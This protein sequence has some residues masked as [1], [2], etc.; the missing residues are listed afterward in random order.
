MAI[1]AGGTQR[2][3]GAL[4]ELTI[5]ILLMLLPVFAVIEYGWLFTREQQVT[6]AARVGARRAVLPDSTNTQVHAVVDQ[7]MAASGLD[8]SGY[9]TT[10]ESGEI[11]D[12]TLVDTAQPITVSVS[13]PY[14]NIDLLDMAMLPVPTNL[15]A[16]VT[17]AKEGPNPPSE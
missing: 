16:S 10:I 11:T 1:V 15:A 17:M 3:G 14:G 9:S 2:R 5:G 7:F 13:V 4:L 8:G 12:V 6:N